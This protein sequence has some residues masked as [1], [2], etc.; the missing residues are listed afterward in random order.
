MKHIKLSY[1]NGM[2]IFNVFAAR[3]ALMVPDIR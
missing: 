2:S 3:I 1:G